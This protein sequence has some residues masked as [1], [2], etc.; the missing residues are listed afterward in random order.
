MWGRRVEFD[1]CKPCVNCRFTCG[2][3]LIDL[4]IGVISLDMAWSRAVDDQAFDRVS[5]L[6]FF[7]TAANSPTSKVHRLGQDRDVFV[8]RLVIADTVEDRIL[9]MQETKVRLELGR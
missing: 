9:Q 3:A 7:V 2:D 5:G 8:K 6:V 4:P 1:P